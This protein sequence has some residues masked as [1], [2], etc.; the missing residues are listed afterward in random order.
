M[1]KKLAMLFGTVFVLVGFLGF[2]SKSPFPPDAQIS[3]DAMTGALSR[4]H[5]AT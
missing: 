3:R 2:V 1:A 4:Y 5:A